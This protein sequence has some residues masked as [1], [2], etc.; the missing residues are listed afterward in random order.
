MIGPSPK[1]LGNKTF[2]ALENINFL[3]ETLVLPIFA[4]PIYV[5]GWQRTWDKT[6]VYWEHPSITYWDLGEHHWECGGNSKKKSMSTSNSMN[7]C[8]DISL[9]TCKFYTKNWLSPFLA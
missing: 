7:A 8:L 6:R 5:K 9:A 4:L 1:R 2:E 3:C